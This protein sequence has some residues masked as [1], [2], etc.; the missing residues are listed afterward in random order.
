MAIVSIAVAF[1][2]AAVRWLGGG[3]EPG[4][5]T[6]KA[7]DSSSVRASHAVPSSQLE[8]DILVTVIVATH[9]DR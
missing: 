3:I 2:S 6:D 7:G 5:K 9:A 1:P 4:L 8:V